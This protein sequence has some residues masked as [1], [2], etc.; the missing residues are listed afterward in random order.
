MSRR[1]FAGGLHQFQVFSLRE[2]RVAA[3]PDLRFGRTRPTSIKRLESWNGRRWNSLAAV[4]PMTRPDM[5]RRLMW[6]G[7]LV[8]PAMRPTEASEPP[9]MRIPGT[10]AGLFTGPGL[11][12]SDLALAAPDFD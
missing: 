6:C 4:K 1:A 7:P 9:L 12:N 5:P 8:Q 3:A 11:H 2:V 10:W